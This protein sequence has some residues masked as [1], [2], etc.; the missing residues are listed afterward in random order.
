MLTTYGAA[1][2]FLLASV[3]AGQCLTALTG[4][5]EGWSVA[6]AAGLAALLCVGGLASRLPE[7]PLLIALLP[8]LVLAAAAVVVVLRR[9][10][11][12]PLPAL[13]A[14]GVALLVAAVPFY[15]AGRSGLLG[16]SLN[17]DTSVHLVWAEALRSDR[18]AA[19]YRCR[20]ATR[21]PRTR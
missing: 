11:W 13:C 16:V 17:N 10:P 14:A 2:C 1:L 18:M 3:L 8:G 21:S 19:L 20:T 7:R 4:R 9:P 15:V 5:R 6:P 12:P